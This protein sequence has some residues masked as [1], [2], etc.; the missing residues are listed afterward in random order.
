M[1]GICSR[2]LARNAR[3]TDDLRRD[4]PATSSS[5]ENFLNMLFVAAAVDG[6][7]ATAAVAVVRVYPAG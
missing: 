5:G 6:L 1:S 3:C 2:M 7:A 4:L